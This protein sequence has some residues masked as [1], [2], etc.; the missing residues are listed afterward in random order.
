VGSNPT[1]SARKP[2]NY[3]IYCRFLKAGRRLSSCRTWQH[4]RCWIARQDEPRLTCRKAF[5]RYSSVRC[6][7]FKGALGVRVTVAIL[8]VI[9][10]ALS[11][12]CETVGRPATSSE[13]AEAAKG[14]APGTHHS[15]ARY[16][17]YCDGTRLL[18]F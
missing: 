1:L 13:R 3:A 9:T 10:A 17:P 18:P 12:G 7:C 15:F 4:G 16:C 14:G 6:G 8:M 11:A 2:Q 5:E